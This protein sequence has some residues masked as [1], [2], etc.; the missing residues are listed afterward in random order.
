VA[1]VGSQARVLPCSI[2][3]AAGCPSPDW[4]LRVGL[5]DGS[6][7][8]NSRSDVK[9]DETNNRAKHF[10]MWKTANMSGRNVSATRASAQPPY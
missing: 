3:L 1:L 10:P 5:V 2:N 8:I 9:I 6:G 7:Q 4:F